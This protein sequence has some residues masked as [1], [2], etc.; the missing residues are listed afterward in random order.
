MRLSCELKPSRW[1]FG[2]VCVMCAVF[3]W[4]LTLVGLLY[5]A[6][7]KQVSMWVFVPMTVVTGLGMCG[8]ILLVMKAE[9]VG[10]R[11]RARKRLEV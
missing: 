2:W 6:F 5:F 8:L 10:R 3:N 11:Y 9:A 4:W 7:V 1:S